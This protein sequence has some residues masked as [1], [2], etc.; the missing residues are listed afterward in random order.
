MDAAYEIT[1]NE[2]QNQKGLHNRIINSPYKNNDVRNNSHFADTQF[3][4]LII[5]SRSPINQK[6][7]HPNSRANID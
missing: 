2:R 5:E 4:K 7:H 1:F 6:P 3:N